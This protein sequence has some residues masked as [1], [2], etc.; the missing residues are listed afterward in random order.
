MLN[1]KVSLSPTVTGTE[2]SSSSRA[3]DI[4]VR[5]RLGRKALMVEG[6]DP[7]HT[8]SFTLQTQAITG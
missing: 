2:L 1:M 3:R 4:Y 7:K 6:K 5:Q 8:S